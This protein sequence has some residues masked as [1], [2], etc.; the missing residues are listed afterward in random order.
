MPEAPDIAS[1]LPADQDWLSRQGWMERH[2]AYA[3]EAAKGEAEIIF[4]GDSITEGLPQSMAW[5][6]T[7]SGR[8][9]AAFGISGD[10]TAQL[11]WRVENGECGALKPR[12]VFLLIGINNFGHLDHSPAEVAKG[13]GAVLSALRQ[14]L[15]MAKICL[16]A[17]FPSGESPDDPMR[18]KIKSA[19][20]LI[21][22]L[23]DG[24]KVFFLDLESLF[25]DNRRRIPP[26]LMPDFLHPNEKGYETWMRAIYPLL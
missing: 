13:V 7:M 4:Y 26:S 19:N 11:L 14:R 24:S 17:I 9:A 21:S 3:V 10:R 18:A 12:L 6:K 5:K 20:N 2:D 16:L 22:A 23:A 15:S 25:L 8:K 1:P